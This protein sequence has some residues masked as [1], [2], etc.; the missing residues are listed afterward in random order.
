MS[1]GR[2]LS[3]LITPT[4]DHNKSSLAARSGDARLWTVPVNEVHPD[5]FQPRRH[6]APAELDE[7]AASIKQHGVLQPLL[8]AEEPTG[9]YRLIA[10][11]RR[12]RAAQ[13]AGLATVPVIV[14]Q[15][16][17][18]QKLEVALIENIQRADLTPLEE[19]SAY[20][21]LIKEFNLTQEQ[22]AA[23][24]GKSRP[25]VAN[26]LRL[27]TLPMP[28]QD[29]LTNGKINM[30]QART[31]LALPGASQQLELLSSMLGQKIT[32]RELEQQV[33]SRSTPR[34][35]AHP[36]ANLEYLETKLRQALGA[37]VRIADQKGRGTITIHYHSPEELKELAK[38]LGLE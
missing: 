18:R 23:Q 27:L 2:G 25:V 1:L 12:W 9:G 7:L 34:V 30:S 33:R 19:A 29:A 10:G 11:E 6:F 16:A 22:V 36:N 13:L 24:V 35:V 8:V 15:L 31:L 37:K 26:M 5:K 38:R 14:K 3:A 4:T 32:V 20:E 28:V 21:R 17:D